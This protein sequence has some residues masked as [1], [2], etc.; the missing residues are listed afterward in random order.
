[1]SLITCK[2]SRGVG[3][4]LKFRVLSGGRV[5]S[6]AVGGLSSSWR[7][8]SLFSFILSIA[9]LFG[10]S[11]AFAADW[12]DANGT[13]YTALRSIK[14]TATA[15]KTGGSWIVTDITPV[16]NDTVKVRFKL[17]D[18]WTQNLWCARTSGSSD[19]FSGFYL[20]SV[21]R[22]DRDAKQKSGSTK[23]S[24]TGGDCTV[25]ADYATGK[26]IIDG[27]Y[28]SGTMNDGAEG[29]YQVGS[30]L[31]LFG[32]H[33][34][35]AD[36][37]AA[38]AADDV[39]NRASYDLYYFQLYSSEGTLK[40][41]LMPA[42][43]DSDQ[44][45]G[46]YD[47]V[48]GS[49]YAKA[50]NSGS[51][52]STAKAVVLGTPVKWT[53]LG[54]D[55]KMSNGANW[56][57]GSAPVA[58]QDLDFTLATPFAVIDADIDATFGKMWLG[59]VEK[60]TF[61]GTLTALE[62]S[63]R[64][65]IDVAEGASVTILNAVTAATWTGAADNGLFQDPGNWTCF[66]V[67]GNQV[68]GV[69]A[70][71]A[72]IT[73]AADVPEN[74]WA[75]ADF[76]KMSGLIDLA[77]HV[78]TVPGA[79]FNVT[80]PAEKNVIV[81]GNFEA[82]QVAYGK[83]ADIKPQ[84]WTGNANVRVQ[85]HAGNTYNNGKTDNGCYIWKPGYIEQTFTLLEDALL[86]LTYQRINKNTKSGSYTKSSGNCQIDGK[87]VDSSSENGYGVK[88]RTVRVALAAGS[89][90][91]RF[92]GTSTT[93]STFDNIKMTY[94]PSARTVTDSVGGG[95]LHVDVPAGETVS[96]A[97][98][99]MTGR[100]RF[101]KEGAGTFV[102]QR[103]ALNYDGGTEVVAGTLST[104]AGAATGSIALRTFGA[105]ESD[106]TVRA[107]GT[108]KNLAASYDF[109]NY[110][111]IL[112]GGTLAAG[113]AV[114]L[115][116]AHEKLHY[117][118]GEKGG[119]IDNGGN[120]ITIAKG[121]S[122]TG[123]IDLIG[124]GTTTFAAGVGVDAEGG[125]YVANGT[126]LTI[127]GATQ[128]YLGMLILQNG[129]MLD[130]ATPAS[131]VAA[132]A[133]TELLIPEKG[134]VT[135]TSGGGAFGEGLYAICKMSGVTAE[136]GAKFAPSTTGEL[137]VSWYVDGDMLMLAV[138][139][140][141]GNTW[142]GNANDSNLSNPE[143]WLG[144]AVPTSGTVTI[145][146]S[147]TL[148]VGDTFRPDVI[149]FPETCGAVTIVGENAI[150]GLSAITNLS[151][152][153]CTFEVPVAFAGEICVSQGA[154]CSY[155]YSDNNPKESD[156]GKVRFTGGVTGTSF[157]EGTSRWLDG[158]FTITGTVNCTEDSSSELW[159]LKGGSSLTMEGF[160]AEQSV[161][162]DLSWLNNDGGAFTTAVIRT[163]S[164][165]CLRNEGEF[166]VTEE[167]AMT[168]P[169]DNR[170]IAQ[171]KSQGK[172]KFEK[173]TLGDNG[174]AG[175]FYVANRGDWYTDKHVYIGA[176][177]LSFAEGTQPDT[178]YGFGRR[179][180]DR[181]Y[182][183]P[184]YS[185]YTIGAK[186][187]TTRD[188]I[189]YKPTYFHTV[190]ENGV[191]RTLTLNG[192]AD[193]QDTLTVKGS[194][195]FQVNSDGMGSGKITVTDSVTLAYAS[196]ADLGT[197][198]VTVGASATLEVAS[199]EHMFGG[200]LTL[201]DGATLSFNF[202]KRTVAPQISIA[203]GKTLTVNGAVKVKIP[204]DSKWPT[205]GEKVL[206]TC[207]GFN[208]EGVTVSLAEGA[209][210]WAKS[211]YVNADGNIVLDVKPRGTKVIVR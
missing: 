144:R 83:S 121:F 196:K 190:D 65:M 32:S 169:G 114:T 68:A 12:T 161:K 138:G 73:L 27:E 209:P 207:G 3:N 172:Y 175:I 78:L 58:G 166:V 106:I 152:S 134:A 59:D 105:L 168:L 77:G 171:R 192:V 184:W 4:S 85:R 201:N 50:D 131:D 44:E 92:T 162:T 20:S 200:G 143:N 117:I 31:M 148:T 18:S 11:G 74:G 41:N 153:V 142:T 100:L 52:A 187:G 128:S 210:K 24:T 146:T 56:E 15:I 136:A 154:N 93:G 16:S 26:F 66:N 163:S 156:G 19:Q 170:H 199:G 28:Q 96:N 115:L 183:Y 151:S 104:S 119:T 181:I 164:L 80:P 88:T 108:L 188:V 89:H 179:T 122:G 189:V 139:A 125:V 130:I 127:N 6:R 21:I 53:G 204:A 64:A 25:V 123:M 13:G 87:T 55:N 202:T 38:I 7:L 57:G 149:V 186:G 70:A 208:A 195:R 101:V 116:P 82:D 113:A 110:N 155:N 67:L 197:G 71:D 63:D 98:V 124:S 75:D 22:C 147:G 97:A 102:S 160:S 177:G 103:T 167:L 158:A 182:I 40:H 135:L 60:T 39:G 90:T 35:G 45:I 30:T 5:S 95:E 49:F 165:V 112:D 176:G 150:T 1:M 48:T 109:P 137:A 94:Q 47:T 205:A 2:K 8:G 118:V 145:N 72:A 120:N 141:D 193:V 133:A 61:A 180:N 54:G 42:V 203:E 34:K 198:A 10:A 99:N 9:L 174:K 126:T 23:P 81:N 91:L 211:V 33:E 76:A 191:P 178:A 140:I 43:R 132:F 173:V 107:D 17:N 51:F 79:F 69:P 14:A 111:V 194:G 157:A 206:T 46:L 86:T 62:A 129:S 185:D 37:T 36:L 29:E 84:G 159:T